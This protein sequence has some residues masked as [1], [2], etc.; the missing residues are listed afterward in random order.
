[1]AA[2]SIL[3]Y[4]KPGFPKQSLGAK[5]YTTSIEYVGPTATLEAALPN[6]GA[7]WGDYT[8]IV[9]TRDIEPIEGTAGY[10]DLKI[11]VSYEFSGS[12]STFGEAREVTTEIEWVAQG[13]RLIEHP[14]LRLGGGGANALTKQDVIDVGFWENEQDA[15]LKEAYQYNELAATGSGDVA[16]LTTN[17]KFYAT[18]IMLG[19]D[20]Y[21]DFVP[22]ARK[23]TTYVNGPPAT[24]TA[25]AKDTPTGFP[26]L[27]TGYEWRKSADRS[28]R[29]GGQNRWER[30]EEWT[31]APKVLIDKN[32]I[33]WTTA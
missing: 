23:H 25:G 11:V 13:K 30:T 20:P 26:N 32:Q 12:E 24:S 28:I 9:E 19:Q 4:K 29:A 15:T 1:M 8:G 2:E 5:G 10:S 17:G 6:I 3:T 22:V 14:Q 7:A 33:Y 31:G 27:P 21:D 16:E 18:G